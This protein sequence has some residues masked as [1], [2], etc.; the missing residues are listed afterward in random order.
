MRLNKLL[1]LCIMLLV[2]GL[3]QPAHAAF[4]DYL[5]TQEQ[6]DPTDMTGATQAMGA[7][8]DD[9]AAGSFDIGFTFQFEG[10]DYNT[11][12]VSSNGWM[13]L[14]A[15]TTNSQ[16]GNNLTTGIYPIL[17]GLWDDLR[18][19]N[20]GGYIRYKTEGSPGS[21]VLTVEWNTT[22]WSDPA[23]GPWIWQIRLYETTGVVE[24][25]YVSMPSNY[26][27]T[28]TIGMA[29]SASNL[30]S[31]TPGSPA[32]TST[33]TSNNSINLNVTPIQEGTMY[34]F[35]RV[36][37]DVA[38]TDVSFSGS[39]DANGFP[40][41]SAVTVNASFTNLGAVPKNSVPVR[42]DVYYN[43]SNKV[44]TSETGSVSPGNRFGVANYTFNP[45][46][47]SVNNR[48]GLYQVRVY[49]SAPVDE[50]RRNDTIKIPYF[51]LGLDDITPLAILSPFQNEPPLYSKYPVSYGV[52]I[53]VRFLNVG[54]RDQRDVPVRYRILNG[55]TEV[56]SA[57]A[58]IPGLFASTSFRDI[59]LPDWTPTQPGTYCLQVIAELENDEDRSNDTIPRD[60]SYC[61]T[62]AFEV[63][64]AAIG[65]GVTEQTGSYPVGRPIVMEGILENSGL[66]DATNAAATMTVFDPMG[67]R[68]YIETVSVLDIPNDGGRVA[69]RF[70][71]FVPPIT[72][73]PGRYT[74]GLKVTHPS[75]PVGSNDSTTFYFNVLR[76]LQG[77]ILVGFG[78]RFNTIQEAR[79]S[80][81]YLGVAGPVDFVLV[82][83]SYVV[84]PAKEDDLDVPAL[85]FRG[86]IIG[87]GQNAPITWKVHPNKTRVDIRLESPSGIGVWF[88]QTGLQNPNGY[89]TFDG[90]DQKKLHFH[91]VNTKGVRNLA[92][93]FLFGRGASNYTVRNTVIDPA[94]DGR[95]CAKS[96]TLPNYDAGFN[97]FTYSGDLDLAVSSGIMLRNT[98]PFEPGTQQN[99]VNA[100][101]LTNQNNR[102]ESNEI[103]GFAYGVLSVGAGPIFRSQTARFEVINNRN[104]VYRNNLI[105]NV[106]RAGIALAYESGSQIEGN[107][108][109]G[110]NNQ[111]S[112]TGLDYAAGIWV[113]AGGGPTNN[114]AFSNDLVI[115]KNVI[116]NIRANSG[117]AGGVLV[118]NNRNVLIT[119]ANVVQE[120]PAA[121]NINVRNNFVWDY[122]GSVRTVGVGFGIGALAGTNYTPSG[123]TVH[124]NTIYNAN[125]S[126]AEEFGI[127]IEYSSASVKN[128]IVAVLNRYA[129][130]LGY[131]ARSPQNR[132]DNL[133]IES[134]YNLLWAPNGFTG[135]LALVSPE[136]YPLPGPPA[137]VDLAQWRFQT[138]LD[139]NSTSG[140]VVPE[141]VSTTSGSVDLHLNPQLISSIAGNRGTQLAN[142][143]TDIDGDPRGQT[144]ISGRYDIGADEFWGVVH[145]HEI[146]ADNVLEPAGYRA[147]SGTFS[148]AEYVMTG[149]TV[150]LKASIRNLGGSPVASAT[151][152]LDVEYWNGS[153]WITETSVSRQMSAD[154]TEA[155]EA[156]FGSFQPKTMQQLGMT[157]ATFGTMRPN[158]SP[159]YRLVISTG[160]DGDLSNNRFEKRVRFYV[161]RSVTD[162]IVSVEE[163][164]PAGTSLPA[165]QVAIGN[166]LNADSLLSA[167]TQM[168]W[169]RTGVDAGQN[170]DFNYDLFE[171]DRWPQYALNFAPWQLLMWAQGEE[172]EGL[173]PE[174]RL[175]IKKQQE[176][177]D[178]WRPAGLFLMGQEAARI[179]DVALNATNG[180]IADRE[181]VEDY[182]RADYRGNTNPQVYDDLRV[183][184]SRITAGRFEVVKSTG[185]AG[186]APPMPSVVRATTGDGVAQPSH[187]YV[188][189]NQ[190]S[191]GGDAAA[192]IAA[193]ARTRASVYYAIDIRHFGRFAPEADR[194][195]VFRVVLGAI[196]F[197]D[198]NGSVLPVDIASL[199]AVQTGREA[200]TV[201][202]KTATEKDIAGLELERA[203]VIS[204]EAGDHVGGYQVIAERASEGGP[205][206]AATYS[207]LDRNVRVGKEYEY[208]LVSIEKDGS[209]VPAATV[210]VKVIG[211]ADGAYALR[212]LPNPVVQHGRIVWNAPRGEDVVVRIVDAR[213][214]EILRESRISEGE[215]SIEL[216]VSDIPSGQYQ[217]EL[218]SGTTVLNE[219]LQIRK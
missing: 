51:V 216:N 200:V 62:T 174:E 148:D 170:A 50:E 129:A 128:N 166:R 12:T 124:N 53:E 34:R 125:S 118:E 182:L 108:I 164:A 126:S 87:S 111:C 178:E 181:F 36:L 30:I 47:G 63:D 183:Q 1:L 54:T 202:W 107:R 158:V 59:N 212:V 103:S 219:S 52:P 90:G 194:S 43:G 6:G 211:S 85:D 49:A 3:A 57:P 177:W 120:F 196:D 82:D 131:R 190:A 35:R 132:P 15:H 78:E 2:G 86:D 84:K 24:I 139:M 192:G 152:T 68:V 195:G 160:N 204:T 38:T 29:T 26:S 61:F 206:K 65:G 209:R 114:R 198:Q 116:S 110:V 197:L 142:V 207:E 173:L 94:A 165:G 104:N 44:Y 55:N 58:I 73:G 70:P 147:T 88:G 186:D 76:P 153:T 22:Y 32:T 135:V 14:G 96:I 100:D 13:K 162:A 75:D 137:A 102:F 18:T 156:S 66:N 210:R 121:S 119:P 115:A 185:A 134:D 176:S 21:R 187:M 99:T 25:V 23:S 112:S 188:D 77:E 42:F 91:M 127:G 101:T 64:L 45:I 149:P 169:T 215:G 40:K 9:L 117:M 191:T 151:A 193:A 122:A 33:T 37:D 217:I 145:N 97:R 89:M 175:A 60:G 136:G 161:K 71:N 208:R 10:V 80:L 31:V 46:P 105:E 163:F 144:A 4:S 168:G 140:N 213:G 159:I 81:V 67:N 138:G 143:T 39:N 130:A 16:L 146:I 157:D 113:T 150:D 154:L 93:A 106:G 83:D 56:Y 180:S 98:M 179:H 79:D 133:S 218:R 72:S 203:E 20:N 205:D 123:N 28:A 172:T 199:E 5:F 74:V 171:R 27:T 189:H 201:T 48:A 109:N 41:N 155:S 11:F 17:T 141:F 184:G 19:N 8:N 69:Q 95:L 7:G 167:L 92:V 214:E